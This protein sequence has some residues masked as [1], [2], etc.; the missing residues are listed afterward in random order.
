MADFKLAPVKAKFAD[1]IWENAPIMSPELVKL[2]EKELNWKKS[3]TYTELREL[4]HRGLFKNEKALVSTL[5]TK[6]EFYAG[7]SRQYVTETFG[8]SLP[9]FL[10]AF[11][12]ES[13]LTEN[14]V[15][16]IESIIR[17][18]VEGGKHG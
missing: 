4:C 9:R 5:I 14:Q 12:S 8:G 17:K 15:K 10:T 7:H 2:C 18:H 13:P 11:I 3:T 16:E 6:D 1:I